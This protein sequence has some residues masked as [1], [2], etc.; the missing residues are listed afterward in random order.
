LPDRVKWF[1]NNPIVRKSLTHMAR[2]QS[3]EKPLVVS[4]GAAAVP[5]RRKSATT[6]RTV[7]STAVVAVAAEAPVA[8]V[9][10]DTDQIAALAYSFWEARGYQGGSPEE[11]WLRAEKQLSALSAK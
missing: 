8:V 11:D 9:V 7:P 2:K 4:S 1:S 6:K 3:S 10:P 5:V